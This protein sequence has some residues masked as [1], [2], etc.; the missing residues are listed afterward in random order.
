VKGRRGRAPSE[1]GFTLPELLVAITILGI[2]MVAIG[3]MITTSFRTS[4]TVSAELQGSRG[5]KVVS[6]YWVPDVEQADTVTKGGIGCVREGSRIATIVSHVFPSAFDPGADPGD[7]AGQDRTIAWSVVTN[8]PRIQLVR[9]VCDGATPG[10]RTI[11]VSDLKSDASA[12]VDDSLPPRFT[13]SV[14]VPD[15]SR[16]NNEYTFTVT[17][18]SQVTTTG[19]P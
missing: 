6:R 11:V 2:I 1:S 9:D 7:T 3:A 8:G 5:P 4:E 17:A 13:I 15:K 16:T 14:T 19:T 12:S 10:A 18:M